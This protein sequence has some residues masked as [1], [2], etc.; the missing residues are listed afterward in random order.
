[1][2]LLPPAAHRGQVF[3]E[4]VT[5]N[6]VD[7]LVATFVSHAR[8]IPSFLHSSAGSLRVQSWNACHCIPPP[9]TPWVIPCSVRSIQVLLVT[10]EATSSRSCLEMCLTVCGS[11]RRKGLDVLQ[12]ELL[13]LPEKSI[14]WP[15][16][17]CLRL[18]SCHPAPKNSWKVLWYLCIVSFNVFSQPDTCSLE[19]PC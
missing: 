15:N 3:E 8:V 14:L 4:R 19:F 16:L 17:K 5:P 1:M 9:C 11:Q 18:P 12:C 7:D 6:L 10:Q 13:V 2:R